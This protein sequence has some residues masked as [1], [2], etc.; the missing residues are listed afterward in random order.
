MHTGGKTL[1]L[2]A[3]PKVMLCLMFCSGFS[4]YNVA[5]TV[6]YICCNIS[7]VARGYRMTKLPSLMTETIRSYLPKNCGNNNC[8]Q[9]FGASCKMRVLQCAA[10]YYRFWLTVV[11]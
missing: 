9:N 4:L 5:E 10:F 8:Q 7:I 11:F 1:G 2:S 6:A 3:G